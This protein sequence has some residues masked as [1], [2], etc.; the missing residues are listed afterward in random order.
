[1]AR[2]THIWTAW[3][4]ERLR[5]WRAAGLPTRLIARRFGV[6]Q[7][8]VRVAVYRFGLDTTAPAIGGYDPAAVEAAVQALFP[9][10]PV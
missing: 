3:R 7:N 2:P 5:R 1:M 10:S 4:I 9:H 6:S 8:A